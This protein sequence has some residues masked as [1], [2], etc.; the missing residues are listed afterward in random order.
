MNFGVY[1]KEQSKQDHEEKY[2]VTRLRCLLHANNGV[3]AFP[4][5][6]SVDHL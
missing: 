4:A 2:Q 5:S 3:A 1:T 6:L